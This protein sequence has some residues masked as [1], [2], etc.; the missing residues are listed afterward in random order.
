MPDFVIEEVRDL[1]TVWPKIE[2]LLRDSFEYYMP[3]VGYGPPAD[4]VEEVQ[5]RFK[6]GP[7]AILLL[8]KSEG[9]ALA[10]ANAMLRTAPGTPPQRFAYL[11]NVYVLAEARGRGI[12]RAVLEYVE[13]WAGQC[14]V[15]AVHLEVLAGN[16]LAYE[17]WTRH[18]F[19]VDR[20]QLRKS[21]GTA[22]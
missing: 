3:I 15:E 5:R 8:V 13:T 19:E 14:G 10:F 7:D 1:E 16:D 17:F 18:G 21:L 2:P 22:T 12:G 11:D 9:K 20:Y 6:P 4:W